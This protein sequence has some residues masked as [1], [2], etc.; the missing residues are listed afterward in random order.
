M[1]IL[2]KIF[3]LLAVTLTYGFW[4]ASELEQLGKVLRSAVDSLVKVEN[5]VSEYSSGFSTED[6]QKMF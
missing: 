5:I 2:D 1:Q 6:I 3:N 4:K